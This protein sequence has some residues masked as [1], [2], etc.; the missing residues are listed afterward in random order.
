[1]ADFI[2]HPDGSVEDVRS[3]YTFPPGVQPPRVGDRPPPT[4]RELLELCGLLLLVFGGIAAVWWGGSALFTWAFPDH[5]AEASRAFHHGDY[6]RAIA[7]YTSAIKQRPSDASRYRDRAFAYKVTGR[8]EL[9]V[10]DYNEALR[11]DPENSNTLLS[12][13]GCY[14]DSQQYDLAIEDYNEFLRIKGPSRIGYSCR[15]HA[16]QAKKQLD[17]ALKDFDE[18]IRLSLQEEG[19]LAKMY[20]SFLYSDRAECYAGIRQYAKAAEDFTRSMQ[21]DPAVWTTLVLYARLLA[22]CREDRIR[23]GKGALKLAEL[24]CRMTKWEKAICLDALAAAHAECGRFAEAARWQKKALELSD[25]K[26]RI[27]FGKPAEVARARRRLELYK[28]SK[29]ARDDE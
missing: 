22:T 7:S 2:C 9:A 5:G 29:P 24:A 21:T 11:L 19:D 1:M 10:E 17:R 26:D 4:R 16:Y 28:A 13:A 25:G 8:Y 18:A 12:R 3:R 6:D 27:G 23:D 15:A 20:R 14:M